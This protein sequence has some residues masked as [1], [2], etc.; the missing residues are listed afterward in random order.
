MRA[1]WV[2]E[3]PNPETPSVG[4]AVVAS[5]WPGRYYWISTIQLDPTSPLRRMTEALNTRR[6]YDQVKVPDAYLTSVYRC[7]TNLGGIYGDPL[8][9]CE[10]ATFSEAKE[11]HK[12]ALLSLTNGSLKLS[13]IKLEFE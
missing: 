1:R 3:T 11:G 13:P 2:L 5:W 7:K 4:S 10:Y 6:P 9:Q 12:K 8:Y